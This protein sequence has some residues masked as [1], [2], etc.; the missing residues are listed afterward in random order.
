MTW[1]RVE[2]RGNVFSFEH[3]K[4][5]IP[6]EHPYRDVEWTVESGLQ[7]EVELRRCQPTENTPKD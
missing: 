5:E 1:G 7:G 6:V 3:S 2:G 4:F